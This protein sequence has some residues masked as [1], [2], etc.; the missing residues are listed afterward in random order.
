ME[1]KGEKKHKPNTAQGIV[2]K[3]DLN[4]CRSR[5][6]LC[7]N[8][9]TSKVSRL[10]IFRHS[11]CNATTGKEGNVTLKRLDLSDKHIVRANQDQL[12]RQLYQDYRQPQKVQ[13][14]S[15]LDNRDE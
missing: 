4:K 7:I 5:M 15:K 11:R 6:I 10:P 14:H 12:N 9:R 8:R 2:G 3:H 13:K 1:S